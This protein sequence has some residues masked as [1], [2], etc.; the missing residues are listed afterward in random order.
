VSNGVFSSKVSA[1][2]IC[3][4]VH[5][6]CTQSDGSLVAVSGSPFSLAGN[7]SNPGPLA[8][9]PYGNNVY[10]VGLDSNTVS[11]FKLSPTTGALTAMTPAVVA[12]GPEPRS[13]TIRGDDNW[14]FIANHN[15]ATVS[16][17]SIVPA[18]GALTAEAPIHTDNY[19]WGVAVK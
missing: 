6:P 12:T 5:T 9:D 16:Q 13:I 19:P 3:A 2:L 8:V 4:T 14:M 10:V 1:Y 7:A 17:Y 11:G 18:T 15:G